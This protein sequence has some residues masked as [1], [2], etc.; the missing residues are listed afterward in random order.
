MQGSSSK[1]S[2]PVG[3]VVPKGIPPFMMLKYDQ[4]QYDK[5]SC[6]R[7]ITELVILGFN[8]AKVIEL[9]SR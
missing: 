5:H 8:R 9:L 6:S 4:K 3:H 2:P 1:I 7:Y